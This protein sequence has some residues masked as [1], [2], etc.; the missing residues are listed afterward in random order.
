MVTSIH[1][2]AWVKSHSSTHPKKR[3]HR[4][5]VMYGVIRDRGPHAYLV[6]LTACTYVISLITMSGK[7]GRILLYSGFTVF[8]CV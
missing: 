6:V 7:A 4:R 2:S 8:A 5:V 3:G 1:L